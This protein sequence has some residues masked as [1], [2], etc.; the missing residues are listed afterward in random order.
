MRGGSWSAGAVSSLLTLT[1][2]RANTE[3]LLGA[4]RGGGDNLQSAFL[5][6]ESV[7][8]I[9]TPCAGRRGRYDLLPPFQGRHCL[10][11]T[12]DLV[13]P[14]ACFFLL[15][16]T[17]WTSSAGALPVSPDTDWLLWPEFTWLSSVPKLCECARAGHNIAPQT[18]GLGQQSFI[19]T[20]FWRLEVQNQGVDRVSSLQGYAGRVCSGPSCS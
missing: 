8:L 9:F 20:E 13:A 18:G 1:K 5:H 17:P 2:I 11:P 16:W 14:D 12:S 4:E 19:V 6:A 10:D 15:P 3:V 7:F